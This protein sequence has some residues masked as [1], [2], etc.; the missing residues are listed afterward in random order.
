MLSR[1]CSSVAEILGIGVL[2]GIFE[3]LPVSSKTIVMLF[4][5]LVLRR[6]LAISYLLGLAIQGGTVFA[7]IVYFRREILDIILFKN[8]K[9]LTYLIVTTFSSCLTGIP[10]YIVFTKFL[11]LREEF[12]GFITI[13]IGFILLLQALV[14]SRLET[15]LKKIT[16]IDI[17]DSLVLGLIQGLSIAPGVSRSG[18]TVAT[19]LYLGY[20]VDDSLKLS[21]LASIPVNLGA[22]I[23]TITLEE[24]T[25]IHLDIT[26]LGLAS[27]VSIITGF[28]T[29]KLL[30]FIA[31][32]YSYKLT[33]G[34]G[35]AAL[36]IGLATAITIY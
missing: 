32:K 35:I 29:I 19:L 13:A 14:L 26:L 6:P 8:T 3:W 4:S 18:V 28:A 1:M 11:L 34:L 27:L 7:A 16:D 5:S 22:T 15:G 24:L 31:K 10:I 33:A 20:T 25:T 17:F 21:F 36:L 30:L 9:L 2:Q 23:L 12:V